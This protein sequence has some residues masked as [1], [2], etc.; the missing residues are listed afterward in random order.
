M[1]PIN[2]FSIE[3]F[4]SFGPKQKLP[5]SRINFLFGPNSHGKSSSL[6]ALGMLM[7]GFLK[8][9]FDIRRIQHL[10]NSPEINIGDNNINSN[11]QADYYI[12]ECESSHQLSFVNIYKDGESVD[13]KYKIIKRFFVEGETNGL[14]RFQALES[15]GEEERL[16]IDVKKGSVILNMQSP[17][18]RQEIKIGNIDEVPDSWSDLVE[19]KNIDIDISR[20]RVS[21]KLPK[22]GTLS[23]ILLSTEGKK[24]AAIIREVLSGLFV[25]WETEKKRSPEDSNLDW[26]GPN[27]LVTNKS[28][29]I[30]GEKDF[31]EDSFL[32]KE[33]IVSMNQ[34]LKNNDFLNLEYQFVFNETKKGKGNIKSIDIKEFGVKKNDDNKFLKL[35]DVGSGIGHIFQIILPFFNDTEFLIIQQPEIHLHP[36]LQVQLARALFS[37]A[38]EKKVQLILETHSEHFIKA[39]QLEIARS[40]NQKLS[41]ISKDDLSVLYIAKDESGFS[42]VRQIQLDETGAFTEPWPDDFFELSA[43]LSMER[44]RQSFKSRN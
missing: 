31:I 33:A 21:K 3:N 13:Y 40:S 32:N 43:D 42:K 8:E 36:S 18:L 10:D 17:Y 39:A 4:K 29:T 37:L 22:S 30:D 19:I 15:I 7:N 23:E 16:I 44:L 35:S 11:A 24:E 28:Y 41:S 14:I 9:K 2:A 20:L 6:T 12:L 26:I 38:H 34:W 5:L 25:T 27:R 1:L